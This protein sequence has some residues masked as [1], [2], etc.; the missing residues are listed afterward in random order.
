[1]KYIFFITAFLLYSCNSFQKKNQ[2]NDPIIQE[3]DSL[4]IV[5]NQYDNTTPD[6][7]AVASFLNDEYPIE[8]QQ[9]SEK[10][11]ISAQKKAPKHDSIPKITNFQEAKK[12]LEGIVTFRGDDSEEQFPT[13]IKFRNGTNFEESDDM[14][15]YIG[16]VAYYPTEDILLFE[17]GHTSDY[18]L[19]LTNGKE[20]ELAGNP[21]YIVHSPQKKNRL[22][23]YFGGQECL[24]YFIQQYKNNEW[25]RTIDLVKI[26]EKKIDKWLCIVKDAFWTDENTLYVSHIDGYDDE[27][28]LCTYYKITLK[29]AENLLNWSDFQPISFPKK[30]KSIIDSYQSSAVLDKTRAK[31]LLAGLYPD[32]TD[33]RKLYSVPF[34]D[35]F[36][37]VMVAFERDQDELVKVLFNLDKNGQ[38][39]DYLEIGYEKNNSNDITIQL[40][41]DKNLIAIENNSPANLIR[42]SY[43]IN[44]KG[45]F[46]LKSYK[47]IRD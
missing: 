5:E 27:K 13:K 12:I 45:Q 32:A 11:F 9:I 7:E 31:R 1:M 44:P 16:F 8:I 36:T 43:Q 38:I 46:V 37:S 34:S 26:F 41:L 22:N 21:E 24:A 39:I 30:E 14:L 3:N 10:E 40:V 42:T 20:T 15:C 17:G 33:F 29:P 18:S 23:A 47:R 2:E 28:P 25:I 19:N 35:K 4:E 6:N